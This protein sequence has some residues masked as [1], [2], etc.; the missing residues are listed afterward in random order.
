MARGQ[1]GGF[2]GPFVQSC[3]ICDSPLPKEKKYA[4]LAGFMSY[5]DAEHYFDVSTGTVTRHIEHAYCVDSF[6][7]K[8]FRKWIARESR[9]P[10][11]SSASGRRANQLL[12]ELDGMN[13][14]S[15]E[16][17]F[18]RMFELEQ[19]ALNL[20]ET[21]RLRDD[22]RGTLEALK[23]ADGLLKRIS[24][25]SGFLST[26]KSTYVVN[27]IGSPQWLGIQ[28][29][30]MRALEYYPEAALAVAEALALPQGNVLTG[31]HE[32][33]EYIDVELVEG[34]EDGV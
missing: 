3:I 9:V 7:G 6:D 13:G 1:N 32:M 31:D 22:D 26:A 28:S 11:T 34:S 4:L 14:P 29:T 25:L 5:I 18:N 21:A 30:I 27:V 23:A 12:N 17:I 16:Q 19:V 10:Q 8:E 20:M 15:L 33:S 24:E 2:T